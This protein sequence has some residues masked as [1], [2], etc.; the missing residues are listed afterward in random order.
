MCDL[1]LDFKKSCFTQICR[2][3]NSIYILHQIQKVL[4]RNSL[5]VTVIYNKTDFRPVSL[6]QH[7][8][9]ENVLNTSGATYLSSVF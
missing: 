5:G 2:L 7:E 3:Q 1:C 8:C 4:L 9:C 6:Q